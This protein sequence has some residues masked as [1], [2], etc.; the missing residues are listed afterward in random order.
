MGNPIR[1]LILEDSADD[2]FLLVH[3]LQV[4]GYDPTYGHVETSEALRAALTTQTWDVILA[5]YSLPSLSALEALA[6]VHELELDLPLIIV[7]GT[8]NEI[9]AVGALKAG[10]NDFI[11]KG[12]W[13]RL[14]PAIAR[15]LRCWPAKGVFGP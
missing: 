4:G 8:I 3:Q 11:I 9:M 14:G 15:E 1:V 5:D 2:A 12:N 7:S 10:A 6:L 13:A